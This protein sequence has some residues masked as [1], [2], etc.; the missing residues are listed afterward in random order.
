MALDA[1][2]YKELRE[3]TKER[4]KNRQDANAI[5]VV[6]WCELNNVKCNQINPYQMRISDGTVI[7][8]IFLQSK[9]WH[10]ITLNKRGIIRTTIYKFLDETFKS[11]V[12]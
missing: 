11:V 7:M 4:K 9:K 2:D 6:N 12:L 3:Q 5:V 8:D 10:N 1:D